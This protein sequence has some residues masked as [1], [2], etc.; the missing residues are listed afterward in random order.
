MID[1]VQFA[2]EARKAV[3]INGHDFRYHLLD[4]AE[5]LETGKL[6]EPYMD[7]VVLDKCIKTAVFA[8]SVDSI[9][10]KPFFDPVMEATPSSKAEARFQRAA[11]LQYWWIETWFKAYAEERGEYEKGLEEAKKK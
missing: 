4:V 5:E 7:T 1:L 10:G 11:K 6:T 8:L 9:D 2:G 3:R